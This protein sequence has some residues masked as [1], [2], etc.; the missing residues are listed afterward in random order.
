MGVL[1]SDLLKD[2]A[3]LQ[4]CSIKNSAHISQKDNKIGAH[5][6][7]IQTALIRIDPTLKIAQ[8]EIDSATYG[9]TT[10]KAVQKFKSDR[11][12]INFTYQNSADDVVGIMTIRRLDTELKDGQ[13]KLVAKDLA[14]ADA[15]MGQS[16]V[17][18]AL[19][20]IRQIEQDI[21][22]LNSGAS[23]NLAV[24]R[25]DALG[26][27]FHL[28]FQVI[29]ATTRAVTQADLDFIKKNYQAVANVFNNAAFAF[30]NG[31]SAKPGSPASGRIDLQKIFFAP[32]YKDFDSPDGAAIGPRTRAAI[33]V[34]EAIHL[35]D[36]LS[37]DDATTHISEF[38][39][40]YE[41]QSADNA[42]HNPSSYATFAWHVTRGFDRPRF[43]LSG[44]ARGM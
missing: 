23:V 13:T 30:D 9:D 32:I 21:T 40:R 7:K 6:T 24:P 31:P 28:S 25:W 4:D 42:L 22:A 16:L 43:G 38:D 14:M 26:T 33:L 11:S 17:R 29:T 36:G 19:A 3:Q 5:V 34:H 10:A 15:P 39:A 41:T 20:A 8:S 37:G 12:I 18:N 27:H 2:N 1:T 35:T 44:V